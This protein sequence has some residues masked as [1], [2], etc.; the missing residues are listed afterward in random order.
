[1]NYNTL[2]DCIKDSEAAFVNQLS[3]TEIR[4]LAGHIRLWLSKKAVS[5]EELYNMDLEPE[6]QV[7]A[8]PMEVLLKSPQELVLPDLTF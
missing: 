6:E 4:E 1:M 8:V 7:E 2:E 3:D 5:S